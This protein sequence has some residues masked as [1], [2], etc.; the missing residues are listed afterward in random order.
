[1]IREFAKGESQVEL[2]MRYGMRIFVPG[3]T[4]CEKGLLYVAEKIISNDEKEIRKLRVCGN[5]QKILIK[6]VEDVF[7]ER[8]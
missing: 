6:T 7:N 4:A 8:K 5:C 2:Q 1:M 3:C